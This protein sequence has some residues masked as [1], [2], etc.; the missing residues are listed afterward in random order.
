[1][2]LHLVAALQFL[3]LLRISS[4]AIAIPQKSSADP[5]PQQDSQQSLP[6]EVIH[7]FPVGNSVENLAVRQNGKILVTIIDHPELYQIDPLQVDAPRLVSNSFGPQTALLGIVETHP[8]IFY[9]VASNANVS[10]LKATS[11]SV[12]KVDMTSHR[13][14][15]PT[16]K[17]ADFPDAGFLNGMA[18]LS[19]KEGLILIADSTVGVVWRLSI[20]T[21]E[22]R[23]IIDIPAMHMPPPPGLP[24]GVNGIKIRDSVLYFTNSGLEA[25]Y[26]IPIHADGTAT[27][28]ASVVASG[29]YGCDDLVFNDEGDVFVTLNT[30]GELIKVTSKGATTVLVNNFTLTLPNPTAVQFGRTSADRESLYISEDGIS[31]RGGRLSRVDV[32]SDY[33]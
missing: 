7:Q 12:W 33:H 15:A 25:L 13:I 11:N 28:D 4:L 24:L 32:G 31:T 21:G 19:N 3:S 1:M 30:A 22:V 5:H 23:R 26:R 20:L 2:Q 16:T 6:V 18:L 17:I 10:T 29:L 14:P 9:V 27:G 8:D